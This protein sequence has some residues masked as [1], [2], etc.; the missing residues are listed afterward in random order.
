MC[1]VTGGRGQC[2][3]MACVAGPRRSLVES[4]QTLACPPHDFLDRRTP[5][6]HAVPSGNPSS[7]QFRVYRPCAGGSLCAVVAAVQPSSPSV[8]GA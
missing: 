3:G 2:R 7:V 8:E 1:L 4:S 6:D 5:T